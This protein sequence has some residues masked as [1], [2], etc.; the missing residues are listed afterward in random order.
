[1]SPIKRVITTNKKSL[2]QAVAEI[3]RGHHAVLLEK[4]KSSG[5]RLVQTERRA[6]T[7]RLISPFYY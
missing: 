4:L 3:P 1:M 6:L 5:K 7:G 2:P